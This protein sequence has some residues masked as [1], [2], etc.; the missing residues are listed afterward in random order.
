MDSLEKLK[1]AII[2]QVK[3]NVPVQTVWATCTSVNLQEGTMEATR[4]GVEY[5]DVLLGLNND[6]MLPMIDQMLLCR[7]QDL[8]KVNAMYGTS[9]F[10]FNPAHRDYAKTWWDVNR[11]T[12]TDVHGAVN[13]MQPLLSGGYM[14]DALTQ[15]GVHVRMG[16]PL[17]PRVLGDE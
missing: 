5:F 14:A 3:A 13:I 1:R 7:Q 16:N 11:L 12:L 17:Q 9:T 6:I 4:D 10:S 2:A 15:V 8:E